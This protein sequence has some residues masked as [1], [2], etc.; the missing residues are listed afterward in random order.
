MI[1]LMRTCTPAR[2]RRLSNDLRSGSSAIARDGRGMLVMVVMVV[3]MVMGTAVASMGSK[4]WM[5]MWMG[6][7][8]GS[9]I[10]R[11]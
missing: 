7:G 6:V 1:P 3:I 9:R 8:I 10:G 2:S 11:W 5:W 4:T